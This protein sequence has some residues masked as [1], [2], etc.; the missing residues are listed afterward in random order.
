MGDMTLDD[1]EDEVWLSL[2][3]HT[4]ADPSVSANQVRLRRWINQAYRRISLPRTYPHPELQGTQTLTLVT[5]TQSY[6]LAATRWAID[7]IR[8]VDRDRI[9]KRVHKE[10]LDRL[11]V[12]QSGEPSYWARWQ[13]TV[14]LNRTPSSNENGQTL[15]V[16][17]W[18]IPT[19]LSSPTAATALRAIFDEPMVE[20]A[21]AIGWRRLGDFARG[22]AHLN[23]YAE[24]VND[25][26]AVESTEAMTDT[27]GIEL[28]NLRSEYMER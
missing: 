4:D 3:R 18:D 9:L 21:A 22:D 14:Y 17:T 25:I 11:N 1:F 20:L 19:A 27:T 12:E 6:A 5:S 28:E 13:N 26:R 10:A 15:T 2:E 7:H 16:H 24:L 23:T 8:Y